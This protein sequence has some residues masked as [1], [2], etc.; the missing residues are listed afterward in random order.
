E[1]VGINVVASGI[2]SVPA[3]LVGAAEGA[4]I[5]YVAVENIAIEVRRRW[6]LALGFG[7]IHGAGLGVGAGATTVGYQVGVLAAT[8][9]AAAVIYGSVTPIRE[10]KRV[11]RGVSIVLGICGACVLILALL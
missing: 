9:G 10:R 2:V 7:V 4:T 6:P 3:K 1:L 8:L 11:I 5:V